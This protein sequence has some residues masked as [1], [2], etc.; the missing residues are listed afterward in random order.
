MFG[1][2]SD[3]TLVTGQPFAMNW[4]SDQQG[5]GHP[6]SHKIYRYFNMLWSSAVNYGAVVAPLFLP[7][8]KI[9]RLRHAKPADVIA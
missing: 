9:C 6:Q 4:T 8:G 2:T 5:P 7:G 3:V 1:V